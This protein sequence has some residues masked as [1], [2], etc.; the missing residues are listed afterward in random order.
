M[1]SISSSRYSLLQAAKKTASVCVVMKRP[2]YAAVDPD[3]TVSYKSSKTHF[4][5]YK[6]N[7]GKKKEVPQQSIQEEEKPDQTQAI[8]Q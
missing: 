3:A 7:I 4:D 6:V 5:V 8:N 1:D 2:S